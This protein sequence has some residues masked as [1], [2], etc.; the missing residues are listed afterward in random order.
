MDLYID[1]LAAYMI[2]SDALEKENFLA[3]ALPPLLLIGSSLFFP[4]GNKETTYGT[5]APNFLLHCNPS[6]KRIFF[7]YVVKLHAL[8]ADDI[9]SLL[10]EDRGDATCTDHMPQTVEE[11]E[12]YGS[13]L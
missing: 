13:H 2:S 4:T 9:H 7:N 3:G 10:S 5:D 11:I 8:F 6:C 1:M 12:F